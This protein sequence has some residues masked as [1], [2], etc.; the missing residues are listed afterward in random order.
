[1]KR[2]IEK[3]RKRRAFPTLTRER[4][5]ATKHIGQGSQEAYTSHLSCLAFHKPKN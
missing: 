2:K 1:M 3:G 4:G 5:I